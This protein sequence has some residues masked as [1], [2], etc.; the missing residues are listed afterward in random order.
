MGK[1]QLARVADGAVTGKL[2]LA[3]ATQKNPKIKL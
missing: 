2:L 1:Q 3:H